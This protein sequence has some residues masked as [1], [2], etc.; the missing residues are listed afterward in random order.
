MPLIAKAPGKQ[1][2]YPKQSIAMTNSDYIEAFG[3]ILKKSV[4][5][6]ADL[7]NITVLYDEFFQ[8]Y[9]NAFSRVVNQ[10]LLKVTYIF[11]PDSY[12]QTMQNNKKFYHQNEIQLPIGINAALHASDVVLNFLTGSSGYSKVRGAVITAIKDNGAKVVHAP[13]L[14]DNVLKII[15]GTSFEKVQ[16]D[17]ELMAWALGSSHTASIQTTGPNNR[18]NE[19]VIKLKG[20]DNDPF[21][22]SGVIANNSWGNVLP[23]EAF[24]CPKALDVN[25]TICING[26]VPGHAFRKNEFLSITFVKGRITEWNATP[27]SPIQSYFKGLQD[28]AASMKD[29]DWNLFAELGI[30]LNPA[31]RLLTGNP[32]FDEKMAG[33]LH[34]AIGD[35]VSFGHSNQSHIHE[36]LVVLNP[37]LLLDGKPVIANGKP[38]L[39]AI[40]AWRRQALPREIPAGLDGRIIQFRQ[41]KIH[42]TN[43]AV[44]R[45]LNTGNRIGYINIFNAAQNKKITTLNKH[46]QLEKLDEIRYTDLAGRSGRHISKKALD[47]MLETFIHYKMVTVK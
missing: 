19:L 11:V 5:I 22:S 41:T 36:D 29:E 15:L 4:D 31:I 13:H 2:L 39:A 28:N 34:I 32:L 24:C 14:D 35:N 38:H 27:D 16:E 8:K 46:I 9:F 47:Q 20:W 10:L 40:K 23:G 43:D 33:T 37:T 6:D 1:K 7:H 12:Q 18:A 30:G 44:K 45:M 42:F 21:I 17:C 26:S 25:G 3:T